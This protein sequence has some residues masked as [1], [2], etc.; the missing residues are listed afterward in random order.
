MSN[1]ME[2]LTAGASLPPAPEQLHYGLRKP[3]ASQPPAPDQRRWH[4]KPITWIAGGIAAVVAVIGLVA[5]VSGGS[6]DAK[7]LDRLH[8]G[9]IN[10]TSS[11]AVAIKAGHSVCDSLDAGH[12]VDQVSNYLLANTT[13]DPYSIGYVVGASVYAY[14]PE[15]GSQIA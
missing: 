2:S 11:D 10:Y 4:E 14:C 13:V 7:Y 3:R 1:P 6:A 9:S 15:Y 12:T 8:D 5:G